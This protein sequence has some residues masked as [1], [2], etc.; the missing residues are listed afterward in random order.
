MTTNRLTIISLPINKPND[1]FLSA[2]ET[3]V[4]RSI[5]DRQTH[6]AG[7]KTETGSC[8]VCGST[9]IDANSTHFD[10]LSIPISSEEYANQEKSPII[11]VEFKGNRKSLF[12]N[13]KNQKI[14]IGDLVIVEAERGFDAGVVVSTGGMAQ[15]KMDVNYEGKP[16]MQAIVRLGAREDWEKFESNRSLEAD[17]LSKGK[18]RVNALEI[19]D[20]NIVD[21]EWQFDRSRISFYFTAPQQVDFRVLVKELAAMFGVRIELRQISNRDEARRLGGVGICGKEF[22]CTSFLDKFDYVTVEH[23]KIQQIAN[24]PTRLSGQC[25]RLKCCLLFEIDYYMAALD[26][27]PPL[28]SQIET[29]D[30]WAK[31]IKI[32][33]F[34][35][36]ITTYNV[37]KS[38]YSTMTLVELNEYRKNGKI[39]VPESYN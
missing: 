7:E 12:T 22:C 3:S 16:P 26:K 11:E 31:M 21:A 4:A 10:E 5:R 28:E 1:K 9:K 36:I 15:K 39:R 17:A 19:Y 30:G 34:K 24:N 32:D 38:A 18:E 25:G 37:S 23:A 14:S 29:N 2:T 27:Y 8:K 33:V 6:C 20:M 13:R 35:D